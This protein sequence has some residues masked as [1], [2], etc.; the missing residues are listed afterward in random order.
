MEVGEYPYLASCV[1]LGLDEGHMRAVDVLLASFDEDRHAITA[2]D[3]AWPRIVL[4][5]IPLENVLDIGPI[6]Q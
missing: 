6:A 5:E 4:V 1:E 3:E 2:V